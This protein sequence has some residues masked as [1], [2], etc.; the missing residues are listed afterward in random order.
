MHAIGLN[1]AESMFMH[2][3]YLEPTQLP[4]KLVEASGIISAVGPT[5]DDNWLNK[6]VSTIP[7]FPLLIF[8]FRLA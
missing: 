8:C 7:A 3:Y 5:V 4:A 6:P 2:G 1:R